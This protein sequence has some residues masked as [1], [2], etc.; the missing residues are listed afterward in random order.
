MRWPW[1]ANRLVW[2]AT[3]LVFFNFVI[4]TVTATFVGSVFLSVY[5][6]TKLPYLY[7]VQACLILILSSTTS[8]L[9]AKYPRR[10][11]VSAHFIGI[12]LLAVTQL[13]STQTMA[14]MPFIA[15]VVLWSVCQI[16]SINSGNFLALLFN[17]RQFK[18]YNAIFTSFGTLLGA[19][20]SF[21]LPLVMLGIGV[22]NL[23][24]IAMGTL[25][26]GLPIFQYAQ[27]QYSGR[28]TQ[29]QKQTQI[30][31]TH[32]PLF[33]NLLLYLSIG[34]IITTLVDYCFKFS[35]NQHFQGVQIANFLTIFN[36]VASLVVFFIQIMATKK[37]MRIFGVVSLLLILPALTIL[38][39]TGSLSYPGLIT[40]TIL[41]FVNYV[42]I[43]AITNI[44]REVILNVL[45]TAVRLKGKSLIKGITVTIG[46]L[47]AALVVWIVNRY[48]G[49]RGVEIGLL[50]FA[51][52]ALYFA[53][54][55][56]K[57]Y[58]NTLRQ[59]LMLKRFN[60]E[61]VLLDDSDQNLLKNLV[62]VALKAND[63][64]LNLLGFSMLPLASF[65][66]LPK[67]VLE[68]LSD[69]NVE[70]KIQ[71]IKA[72]K[73]IKDASIVKLL[74]QQI[75]KAEDA[76]E[77]FYLLDALYSQNI[78]VALSYA[79]RFV[80]DPYP[81][82]RACA[83]DIQIKHGDIK[84]VATAINTL[85]DMIEAGDSSVRASSAEI[86]GD[87]SVG[88]LTHELT[89]LIGDSD[90]IVALNAIRSATKLHK[91][92]T[93]P[94]LIG[95]LGKGIVGFSASKALQSFGPIALPALEDKVLNTKSINIGIMAIKTIA[96]MEAKEAESSL[97]AISTS[98]N[99]VIFH[100][101]A[102]YSAYRAQKIGVSSDFLKH[103]EVMLNKEIHNIT[104]LKLVLP[105]YQAEFYRREITARLR[106]AQKGFLYWLAILNNPVELIP[107]I[108]AL[109][110]HADRMNMLGFNYALELLESSLKHSKYALAIKQVFENEST[111]SFPGNL[112]EALSAI[113]PWLGKILLMPLTTQVGGSMD[114]LQIVMTLRNTN[115]FESLP[116][117]TLLA[118]A[119][120]AKVREVAAN[121]II[122]DQGELPSAVYIIANGECQLIKKGKVILQ[123]KAQ[124]CFGFIGVFENNVWEV[125]AKAVTDGVLLYLEKEVFDQILEDVPEVM[126]AM[127][128]TV[129]GYL[130]ESL[131]KNL[132]R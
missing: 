56:Q 127:M 25:V 6:A 118:I 58:K 41:A 108:T 101:I 15:C 45:P 89:L 124:D 9:L 11:M 28:T 114:T 30:K 49:V 99:Q 21:L 76:R 78:E 90:D 38:T 48:F 110:S 132:V 102:K 7:V 100:Q 36:G 122:Y 34:V 23:P 2:L 112:L 47:M 39:V 44:S 57:N 104:L 106:L 96:H 33:N 10:F 62:E 40:A 117:E 111:M 53:W 26:V 121:E 113:D 82:L 66:V 77:K 92:N 115:L 87:I 22:H 79:S 130:K 74:Q 61:Q 46:T 123:L 29:K 72:T 63:L 125:T 120:L 17:I 81:R 14:W 97:I 4:N 5:G 109:C 126:H 1:V 32:Y 94:A 119:E 52:S 19:T 18:E 65:E 131:Q 95:R 67:E 43:Y 88:D 116:G 103:A 27:I 55:L 13:F 69:S 84:Q 42:V 51:V 20:F 128:Y 37:L 93:I 12:G 91:T 50:L 107:I 35:L 83:I 64:R 75:E 24:M 80:N 8:P 86:L 129:L 59:Q 73:M 71:A 3:L 98:K 70:L 68:F 31:A 105:Q 16:Y 54:R 85:R 60:P